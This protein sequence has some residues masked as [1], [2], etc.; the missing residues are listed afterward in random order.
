MHNKVN[1]YVIRDTHNEVR[2]N[3]MLSCQDLLCVVFKILIN[4]EYHANV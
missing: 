4:E 2:D 3:L 1:E